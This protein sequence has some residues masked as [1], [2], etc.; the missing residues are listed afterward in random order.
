MS[1]HN[2]LSLTSNQRRTNA[3][4]FIES[5]KDVPIVKQ[6][7]DTVTPLMQLG[8]ARKELRHLQR[9][10]RDHKKTNR[11]T[12]SYKHKLRTLRFVITKH[13][14][15]IRRLV[16]LVYPHIASSKPKHQKPPKLRIRRL[17][18][19]HFCKRPFPEGSKPW[20][21]N[22][23]EHRRTVLICDLCHDNLPQ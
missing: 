8:R 14:E 23:P 19:C 20:N 22:L 18:K 9:E 13:H 15:D 2:H 21:H 6:F 1:K 10:L 5:R 3:L 11:Y 12:P 4:R 17:D 16:A 7:S